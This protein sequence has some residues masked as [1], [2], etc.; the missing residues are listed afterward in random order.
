MA[1]ENL[2]SP[3][4]DGTFLPAVG[5]QVEVNG[6]AG[7]VR[8]AGTTSFAAGLWVGIELTEPNGKNDGSVQGT[9][10]FE[11]KPSFGVF[12][13]PSQLRNGKPAGGEVAESSSVPSTLSNRARPTSSPP[14]FARSI[15]PTSRTLP[16]PRTNLTR[17]APAPLSAT[18]P[19]SAS[20]VPARPSYSRSSLGGAGVS[21]VQSPTNMASGPPSPKSRR[22]TIAPGQLPT[23]TFGVASRTGSKNNATRVSPSASSADLQ[24]AGRGKRPPEPSIPEPVPIPEPAPMPE[25]VSSPESKSVSEPTLTA[26][27]AIVSEPASPAESTPVAEPARIHEVISV[28]IDEHGGDRRVEPTRVKPEISEATLKGASRVEPSIASPDE[29]AKSVDHHIEVPAAE[30]ELPAEKPEIPILKP[31]G[32]GS[33]SQAPASPAKF[34]QLVPLRDL[35]ELR[36]KITHLEQKRAEDREK[37]MQLES[38]RNEVETAASGRQRLAEKLQEVQAENKEIRRQLRDEQDAKAQLDAQLAETQ[39]GMEMMLLDKEMAEEKADTLQAEVSALEEKIEE[40]SLDLEVLKQEAEEPVSQQARDITEV[41]S[42]PRSSVVSTQLERQNERL[43]EALVKLRDAS[44]E[45]EEGFREKV[46]A[47]DKEMAKLLEY[48][49]QYEEAMEEL[50]AAETTIEE[51]KILMDD[52]IGIEDMVDSLTERNMALNEKLEEAKATIQDLEA[53]KELNDQLEEDHIETENLLQAEIEVKEGI[54]AVQNR[55]LQTQEETLGDYDRTVRQFREL[56]RTLQSDI[57]HIRGGDERGGVPRSHE[58][59]EAHRKMLDSQSQEMISLNLRLQSTESKAQARFIELELR[60]LDVEQA[61]QEL[62]MIKPYLPASFFTYE[63]DGTLC[64]LLFRRLDFKAGLLA[65]RLQAEKSDL[66]EA[67]NLESLAVCCHVFDILHQIAG[68]AREFG[69]RIEECSVDE[70][71]SFG[72]LHS[73][74]VGFETKLDGLISLVKQNQQTLGAV[75]VSDLEQ[76]LSRLQR[77]AETHLNADSTGASARKCRTIVAADSVSI[78]AERINV[79]LNRYALLLEA[80]ELDDP[81]FP[82]S[83]E[84]ALLDID[85]AWKRLRTMNDLFSST[86]KR[87]L[88]KVQEMGAQGLSLTRLAGAQLDAIAMKSRKLVA[89]HQTIIAQTKTYVAN[90]RDSRTAI[91]TQTLQRIVRDASEQVF[92]NADDDY[93]AVLSTEATQLCE[94]CAAFMNMMDAAALAADSGEDDDAWEKISTARS[95]WLLRAERMRGDYT[96]NADMQA[97]LDARNEEIVALMTAAKIKDQ[98]LQESAVTIELFQKRTETHR[99]HSDKLRAAE[100]ALAKITD[101]AKV[102]EDAVESLHADLQ[103]LEE[104]NEKLRKIAK[105]AEN[106]QHA[107][108]LSPAGASPRS[109][110][111]RELF[112]DRDLASSRAGSEMNLRADD[113]VPGH[114]LLAQFESLKAALRFLRAENSRLKAAKAFV[115]AASLFSPTDPLMKRGRQQPSPPDEPVNPDTTTTGAEPPADLT[116]LKLAT[117]DLAR[118]ISLVAVAPRV[119]D[120]TR[121]LPAADRKWSS[122]KNDPRVQKQEAEDHRR[123]LC[124]RHVKLKEAVAKLHPVCGTFATSRS[125]VDRASSATHRTHNN[126]AD[127]MPL[128]GRVRVRSSAVPDSGSIVTGTPR[129]CVVV[130]SRKEFEAIHAIFAV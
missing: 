113:R 127:R 123:D 119:V 34:S 105:R 68:V 9:R 117:R 59:E 50:N 106:R 57:Q 29:S 15:T 90:C 87:I 18:R 32:R 64:L 78:H 80:Q 118:Q 55:K 53:L 37:L 65:R 41:S 82:A 48:K 36:I 33:F 124:T 77:I 89:C 112:S 54:I 94:Q 101:K 120:V 28:Q 115:A 100:N 125:Q 129:R 104:E 51:L 126:S 108:G 4:G 84:G 85:P 10:Y 103:H 60:K 56:V 83:L 75:A 12:V 26:E 40:L 13:R 21:R 2:P 81:I 72:K 25:A 86:V 73:Q 71:K 42:E 88:R 107:H 63:F 47:M 38:L 20:S 109:L 122:W 67:G 11:C 102:Y 52:S 5:A 31:E 6:G 30:P 97:Q 43:K 44:V 116:R 70:Y 69:A 39:E 92:G 114:E 14:G 76:I 16:T 61:R 49:S 3:T 99:L 128:I 7:V 27:R 35:E 74:L 24:I 93:A 22:A 98:T 17:P 130:R 45:Q 79:D 8:F 19:A 111:A 62:E 110:P 46:A 121:T 95:P 23:T 58:G 66:T 96:V 91:T 1:S